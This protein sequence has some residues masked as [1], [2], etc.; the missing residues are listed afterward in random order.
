MDDCGNTDGS[1]VAGAGE[2]LHDGRVHS[3]PAGDCHCR[4]AGQDHSGPECRVVSGNHDPNRADDMKDENEK[5][6]TSNVKIVSAVG[7]HPARIHNL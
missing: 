3:R 1:L 6:V 2:Q 4:G 7:H 5:R